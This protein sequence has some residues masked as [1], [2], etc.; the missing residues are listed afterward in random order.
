MNPALR[1]LLLWQWT[2]QTQLKPGFLFVLMNPAKLGKLG[3]R[4]QLTWVTYS[5]GS[6]RLAGFRTQLKPRFNLGWTQLS[7]PG[8]TR[9]KGAAGENFWDFFPRY[10]WNSILNEK[11]NLV[12]AFFSKIRT[13]FF[14][15]SKRA[16]ETSPLLPSSYAAV[17]LCKFF[18]LVFTF[19]QRLI[20]WS[21]VILSCACYI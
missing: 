18:F 19:I 6:P 10:T 9:K 16:G 7:I 17:N 1:V 11:F 4:T 13:L 15:F 8:N 2:Q 12:R 14:E 3:S 5:L 20:Y 21:V